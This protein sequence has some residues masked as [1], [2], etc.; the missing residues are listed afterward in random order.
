MNKKKI[1][2]ISIDKNTFYDIEGTL[3]LDSRVLD[4]IISINIFNDAFKFQ[5]NEL[6][7]HPERI[8]ENK[9]IY[10]VDENETYYSCFNCIFGFK[11][12]D[13]LQ[14][15]SSPIDFIIENAISD[16]NNINVDKIIFKTSLPRKYSLYIL[17]MHIKYTR[18][19]DIFINKSFDNDKMIIEYSITSNKKTEYNKLSAIMYS[20]LE[21]SFLCLGDIPKIEKVSVYS[22]NAMNYYFACAPKYIQRANIYSSS[23]NGVLA[24]IEPGTIS[25][26]L[27]KYFIK[28]RKNTKILFDLLMIHMNGDGYLEMTNSMLVQLLE[29]FYKTNN[30]GTNKELREILDFYYIQNP[31]IKTLLVRRDLKNAGD[32][33]NTPI[34]LLKAKEHRHY[35]SH[36]NM[37]ESKKVFFQ[38]ENNYAYWKL[39]HGLRIYIMQIISLPINFDEYDK[40]KNSVERWAKDHRL[41]YKK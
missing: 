16:T 39:C 33:H 31:V 14:I 8:N 6:F 27:V 2:K 25:S 19:K 17:N 23:T 13:P 36:L 3:D 30:P 32:V 5:A 21:L 38:L 34:F 20:L 1:L 22:E 29:G 12:N 7:L 24:C 11:Y 41:R 4:F 40:F 28:F 26:N 15:Y 10:V 9:V 18:T 37:N 35:L